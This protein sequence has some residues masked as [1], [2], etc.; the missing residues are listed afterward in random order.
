MLLELDLLVS[1]ATTVELSLALVVGAIML[2]VF[3]ALVVVEI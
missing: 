1:V 2:V 3:A